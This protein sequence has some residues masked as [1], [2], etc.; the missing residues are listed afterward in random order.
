MDDLKKVLNK[1]F[2]NLFKPDASNVVTVSSPS[3]VADI[4]QGFQSLGFNMKT[5]G[6][7]DIK[8]NL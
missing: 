7:N 1:Y 5:I 6:L 3:K 4:Q 8:L 2:M